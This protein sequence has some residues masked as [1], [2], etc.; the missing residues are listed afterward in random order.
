MFR[1]STYFEAVTPHATNKLPGGKCRGV[2]V[3]TAGT[4]VAYNEQ[5]TAVTVTCAAGVVIPI[6]TD[7]ILNTSTAT[8]IVALF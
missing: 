4:V 5:G 2:I 1:P 8:G 3:G 7:R 6:V